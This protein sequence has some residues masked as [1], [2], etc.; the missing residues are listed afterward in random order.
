MYHLIREYC[1]LGNLAMRD[2]WGGN[3]VDGVTLHICIWMGV[4]VMNILAGFV[5][6]VLVPVTTL[7][8]SRIF[9]NLA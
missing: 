9:R 1:L 3:F 2:F 7:L 8:L 4:F 5:G 6:G